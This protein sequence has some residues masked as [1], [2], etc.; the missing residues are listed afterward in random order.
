MVVSVEHEINDFGLYTKL[1]HDHMV[2]MKIS[3]IDRSACSFVCNCF[4]LNVVGCQFVAVS[5]NRSNLYCEP[6]LI[7]LSREEA[8]EHFFIIQWQLVDNMIGCVELYVRLCVRCE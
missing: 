2:N 6:S 1:Q 3:Y 7:T 4:Y 5:I 8:I